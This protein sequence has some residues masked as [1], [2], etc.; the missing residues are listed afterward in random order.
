MTT[1]IA[2]LGINH[3]GSRKNALELIKAAKLAGCEEVKF[4]YRSLPR[5]LNKATE[6]GLEIIE[7]EVRKTYLPPRDILDLSKSAKD[8]GLRIGISFFS[9]SDL[10]DFLDSWQIFDFFKIPAASNTDFDLIDSLLKFEKRIYISLGMISQQEIERLAIRYKKYDELI[11]FHCISNYPTKIYNSQIRFIEDLRVIWNKEVGYSSHDDNLF[12]I[13]KALDIGISHLER[14]ITFN[15]FD[16]GLDKSSSSTPDE[17]RMISE[18]IKFSKNLNQHF[19]QRNLNQGEVINLQN[20]GK[21]LYSKANFDSTHKVRIEDFEERSP[22]I[23]ITRKDFGE[24]TNPKLIKSIMRDEPLMNSH[25]Y[26]DIKLTDDDLTH[27]NNLN[28]GIPIRFHDQIFASKHFDVNFYEFHLSFKD[29]MEIDANLSKIDL[30]KQYSIHAP[31]YISSTELLNIFSKN[32]EIQRI[33]SK[34]V[35]EIVDFANILQD[36]TGYETPIIISLNSLERIDSF[37]EKIFDLQSS[38]YERNITILPQILPPFAWY[39]GGSV[40]VNYFSSLEALDICLRKN[41][42]IC[43]DLSHFILICNFYKLDKE[44]IFYK[45]RSIFKHYHISGGAGIDAEGLSLKFLDKHELKILENILSLKDKKV[46]EIWQ[47]HTDNFKKFKEEAI[48]ILKKVH[49]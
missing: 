19:Q 47:G 20:L 43:L 27:V 38:F 40:Q 26:A 48:Y 8:L 39:F 1:L 41:I 32:G 35:N 4:Q 2:E 13:C 42:R 17:F 11:P 15:K 33:S 23:G 9:T 10:Q 12:V 24:L 6:L 29:L 14:H 5:H 28:I 34:V 44:E 45:Y 22:Q 36:Q 30:K 3:D 31:D 49:T 25:F 16:V 46:L 18:Y 7:T 37:Y 21:S